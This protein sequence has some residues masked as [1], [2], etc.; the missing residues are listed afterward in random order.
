M[1]KLSETFISAPVLSLRTGGP[2]GSVIQPIID[3]NNLKIEGW[4]VQDQFNKDKLVLLSQDIRDIL[5]QGFAIN[6]HEVL[7]QPE[8]LIRLKEI[9]EHN[10]ELP[11]KYVTNSSDKKFGKVTDYAVETNSMY[12]QKIY[13][14]QSLI[15]NFSGGTL[16]VDRSQIIEITNRRIII[17]DPVEKAGIKATS[18]SPAA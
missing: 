6:D 8:E 3:P 17:E 2:I 13:V 14:G 15:K 9:M 1:L 12:I 16:S 18:P 10:F 4:Y 7:S 5:P 11:G